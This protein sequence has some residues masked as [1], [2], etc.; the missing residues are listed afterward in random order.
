[1]ASAASP[2]ILE[3]NTGSME[4]RSSF[5]YWESVDFLKNGI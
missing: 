5:Y 1:M 4:L 3:K 2:E